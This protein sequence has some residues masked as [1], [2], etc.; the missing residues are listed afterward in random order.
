MF[1]N[2][3]L[4]LEYKHVK[5][6][7]MTLSVPCILYSKPSTP[8]IIISEI[9][10]SKIEWLSTKNAIK[11]GHFSKFSEKCPSITL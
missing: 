3:F 5:V 1:N 11:K 8:C 10:K 4:C 9:I 7:S 6:F 2:S